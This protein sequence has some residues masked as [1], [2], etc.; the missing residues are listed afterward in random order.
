MSVVALTFY[1]GV[2]GFI[3]ALATI[4]LFLG[5]WP[6]SVA[7]VLLGSAFAYTGPFVLGRGWQAPEPPPT[8]RPVIRRRR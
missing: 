1:L 4:A 6:Y 3:L 5:W 7:F 2:L 8:R